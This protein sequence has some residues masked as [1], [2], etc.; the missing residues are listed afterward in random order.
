M[1]L[2]TQYFIQ[3]EI[4]QNVEQNRSKKCNIDFKCCLGL[5]TKETMCLQCSLNNYCRGYK[6]K[7]N[8]LFSIYGCGGTAKCVCGC[9]GDICGPFEVICPYCGRVIVDNT[10]FSNRRYKWKV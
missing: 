7:R 5:P 10:S 3:K 6:I 1:S 4:K 2:E 8:T 9:G